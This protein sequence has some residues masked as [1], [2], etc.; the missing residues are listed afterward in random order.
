MIL[1]DDCEPK[2]ILEQGVEKSKNKKKK[3]LDEFQYC[4]FCFAPS[5]YNSAIRFLNILVRMT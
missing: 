1:N 3:A 5:L 2:K 4:T